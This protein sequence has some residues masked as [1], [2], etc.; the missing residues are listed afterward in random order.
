M[1]ATELTGTRI[2]VDCT[3]PSKVFYVQ[4]CNINHTPVEIRGNTFIILPSD[5]FE[6]E[7]EI[8]PSRISDGLALLPFTND[9]VMWKQFD[10][11]KR[12]RTMILYS[13]LRIGDIV[14]IPDPENY[15]YIVSIPSNDI[16]TPNPWMLVSFDS[17][18]ELPEIRYNTESFE[19]SINH[20]TQPSQQQ[21][22][23]QTT[24]LISLPRFFWDQLFYPCQI[25][26]AKTRD[27]MQLLG[28]F[29]DNDPDSMNPY[30]LI[31][32]VL[33]LTATGEYIKPTIATTTSLIP[34]DTNMPRI[35]R[36]EINLVDQ[37][38]FQTADF[39]TKLQLASINGNRQ[40]LID[41]IDMFQYHQRSW[42]TPIIT[43]RKF[44][45][46]LRVYTYGIL[47][48]DWQCM[49]LLMGIQT[50][51]NSHM[52]GGWNEIW[53]KNVPCPSTRIVFL[54]TGILGFD[55]LRSFCEF[56][57]PRLVDRIREGWSLTMNYKLVPVD[58][59][60]LCAKPT[61][62]L[63]ARN[64]FF[65]AMKQPGSYS[66]TV[67]DKAHILAFILLTPNVNAV[68]TTDHDQE[69]ADHIRSA[70]QVPHHEFFVTSTYFLRSSTN[71]AT[72]SF[73]PS[74]PGWTPAIPN[75]TV[76]MLCIALE[77]QLL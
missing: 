46:W 70:V 61:E 17:I 15:K 72:I 26:A 13:S 22:Q 20:Q 25:N 56:M 68:W 65:D 18:A 39:N 6:N 77:I 55:V 38:L 2:W 66:T 45:T 41:T 21:P 74:S 67:F 75:D 37:L 12:R 10:T 73:V 44:N 49:W 36:M 48:P 28:K 7:S 42:Q 69:K 16:I 3:I 19:I 43:S 71:N 62:Q 32:D 40:L 11:S 63:S 35:R 9:D 47:Q 8:I 52:Y 50:K 31:P 53:K 51:V 57:V 23:T 64:L 34:H 30:R 33:Q 27:A 14:T 58:S 4:S 59:M 5:Y 24:P 29:V 54:P 76:V 1:D 60:L